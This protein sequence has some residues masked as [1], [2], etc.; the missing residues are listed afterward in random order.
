MTCLGSLSR[1]S[2]AILRAMAVCC[3]A[4]SSV[5]PRGPPG[6]AAT[7]FLSFGLIATLEGS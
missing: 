1:E 2:S 6:R 4:D 5:S 3:R 7:R